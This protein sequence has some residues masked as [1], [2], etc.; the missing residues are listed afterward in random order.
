MGRD[1][2]TVK[3]E[4]IATVIDS[5]H[6]TPQYSE[7][8]FPM[9]RVVDVA[10]GKL[11]L[12]NTKKVSDEVYRDFSK[13]REPELED[14]VITRVGSYGNVA[15]VNSK[16]KFCLG[17]NTALI[18]PKEKDRFLYYALISPQIKSQIEDMVVGAVQKTISLKSIKSIELRV[19]PKEVKNKITSI[20]S[21]I[22]EKIDIN[23]SINQT[24]EKIAQALFKSWFVDFDPVIDNALGEGNPIPDELQERAELRKRVIAERAINPKLNPL[25][26]D[27][28]Q[29]FPSEFE[30]SELGWIPKGWAVK[31]LNGLLEIKY[32]KDHKKLNAGSIPVYGSGGVMRLADKFLYV[33][34]SVLIPRKGTLSNIIYVN[35]RFWT[36]DTMFYSV[37]RLSNVAKF[38]F[39]HLKTLDFTAMNVGSAVPSMTT[40]VLNI[41]PL[42][43]P[44]DELLKTFDGILTLQFNKKDTLDKQ[45]KSLQRIRDLLLPKLI[46]GEITLNKDVA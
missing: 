26:E 21:A 28:Q 31:P 38:V 39:Y 13:G 42:V 14:I 32:G 29:L 27:I 9:V 3:L 45:S 20:L 23:K 8:G 11:T 19:P 25:P 41:L 5:R 7:Y 34:E 18:I 22:D 6:K 30:E 17:Q 24:L 36:V 43:L 15:Y 10:S 35:K 4:D 33:G 16:E 1:W 46:S 2:A 44:T 37:P 12:E 40:K